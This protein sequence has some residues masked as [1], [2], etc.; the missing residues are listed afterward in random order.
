M[1]SFGLSSQRKKQIVLINLF[2]CKLINNPKKLFIM[3][4]EFAPLANETIRLK[5]IDL[6][7]LPQPGETVVIEGMKCEIF[8][9]ID[10]AWHNGYIAGNAPDFKVIKREWILEGKCVV[11][12]L[13]QDN[14][15]NSFGS[16]VVLD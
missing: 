7:F 12:Y 9:P 6:E 16:F 3:R 8:E 2:V 14:E 10:N 4:V 5:E 13:I 11:L 15:V 1:L